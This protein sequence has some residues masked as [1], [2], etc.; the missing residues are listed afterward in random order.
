MARTKL[1]K[2]SSALGMCGILAAGVG[3][4]SNANTNA[5]D[6][7]AMRRA[8]AIPALRRSAS[9]R[10]ADSVK[11]VAIR[12]V[13]NDMVKDVKD[14]PTEWFGDRK[15]RTRDGFCKGLTRLIRK[16]ISRTEPTLGF[17]RSDAER[18][19]V[20]MTYASAAGCGTRSGRA[21]IY[22]PAVFVPALKVSRA[23][24]QGD[25]DMFVDANWSGAALDR[26]AIYGD[27]MLFGRVGA[28]DYE[29]GL[30]AIDDAVFV[31][32]AN[33]MGSLIASP[34]V[35]GGDGAG[36]GGGGDGLPMMS[37]Y[38]MP[39]WASAGIAGCISGVAGDVGDIVLGARLGFAMWGP[40]GGIGGAIAVT[41]EACAF[42]GGAALL[43]Y[44]WMK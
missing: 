8:N 42:G 10:R 5:P 9:D 36:E 4:G 20:A 12:N 31:E 41:G 40:L 23:V 30:P 21:S 28:H 29:Q 37:I 1:M 38:F 11:M 33:Q 16:H 24:P 7:S 39:P 15:H 14:H 17:K 3:C 18:D 25:A 44:F 34:P 43:T 13:V 32:G 6:A 35:T 22:A 19:R 26:L 2:V 27:D